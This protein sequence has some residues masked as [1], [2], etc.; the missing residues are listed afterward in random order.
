MN[1]VIQSIKH[2]N[3]RYDTAGDWFN[4]GGVDIICVSEVKNKDY[5][6]LVGL[7]E[8]VEMYLCKKRKIS[9]RRVCDFDK[10]FEKK[11][12]KGNNDEPGDDPKAPYFDEHQFATIIEKMM[13]KEL[14]VNWKKYD[15]ILVQRTK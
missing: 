1:I 13:A 8:L 4:I 3:Q 12:K 9:D 2:K 7:H 11:R 5:E 10:K 14:G 15:S 6:F